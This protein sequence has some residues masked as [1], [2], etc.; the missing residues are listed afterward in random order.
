MSLILKAEHIGGMGAMEPDRYK[1]NH[2]LY[3]SGI[4]CLVIA[5]S[6]FS[7]SLYIVPFLLWQLD[8]DVPDLI[9]TLITLFEYKYEYGI[10]SSKLIVWLIFFVPSLITG[11]FAYYVSNRI[12]SEIYKSELPKKYETKMPVSGEISKQIRESAGLGLKII[13]LMVVIVVIVIF[14]QAFIRLT[15]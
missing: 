4:I 1:T 15:A 12:D 11:F 6:L 2:K 13:L 9:T 7:F 10:V 8:Y 14:L 3:I 5:L